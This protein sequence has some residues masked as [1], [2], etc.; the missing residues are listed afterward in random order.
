MD[1]SQGQLDLKSIANKLVTGTSSGQPESG[2]IDPS[3]GKADDV[4]GLVDGK[5][6]VNLSEGEFV[7]PA[8]V[9]ASIG[10]GSPEA[11]AQI[12]Q[13]MVDQIRK[14]SGNGPQTIANVFKS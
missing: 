7:V 13:S 2:G 1:A 8:D 12:L 9:V 6:P 4:P 10:K 3:K 14:G 11:G 5:E